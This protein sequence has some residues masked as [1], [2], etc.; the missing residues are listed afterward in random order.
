MDA[1]GALPV[2]PSTRISALEQASKALRLEE[3]DRSGDATVHG[4]GLI[5]IK[6]EFL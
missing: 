5:W 4:E 1:G 2:Y 3:D 6:T